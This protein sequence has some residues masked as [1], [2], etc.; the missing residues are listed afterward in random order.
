MARWPV[1]EPATDRRDGES[2]V[3]AIWMKA[4]NKTWI[5]R[6]IDAVE[7]AVGRWSQA[8]DGTF[9]ARKRMKDAE[10]ARSRD[11]VSDRG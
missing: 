4:K 5:G 10:R 7:P 6:S 3:T 9:V 8:T 1:F 11:A 2:L